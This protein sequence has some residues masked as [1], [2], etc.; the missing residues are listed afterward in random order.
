MI[1]FTPITNKKTNW[2]RF[3]ANFCKQDLA[4]QANW[5]TDHILELIAGATDF[6]AVFEPVDP[7]AHDPYAENPDDETLGWNLAH[8]IVHLTASNEESAFLAAELARG[9]KF[10]YRRSRWEVPW[11]TVT[12]IQQVRDRLEESRRILLSSLDMWPEEPHTDNYYK[13]DRGLKI[14][15]AARFLLG[16]NHA[17]QHLG[18][19]KDILAQA[20]A[21]RETA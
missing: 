2:T 16:Q 20:K 15:P 6:D 17:M 12:T 21:A 18:Q 11:E 13:T 7:E 1:D 4:D 19:I 3:S 9:V 5:L 8:V 10:E 14:T